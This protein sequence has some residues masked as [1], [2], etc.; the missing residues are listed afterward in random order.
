MPRELLLLR[1][2]K[3]DWSL[4]AEDFSR[5]LKD[6]GGRDAERMG[7]WL[8]R[9]GWI[10]DHWLCSP[11][12]RAKNTAERCAAAMEQDAR[13]IHYDE[14]IYEAG[15]SPLLEVLAGSPADAGCVILV[16][17]NPGLEDLL[18]H[19][20]GDRVPDSSDHKL[21]PTATLA[22]LT[23]P[24]DWSRLKAGCAH[25]LSIT[26]PGELPR[27]FPFPSPDGEELRKRPAY[28]YRQCAALPYRLRKGKAEFLLVTSRSGQH[29]VL[30]K[31]IQDPGL[32]PWEAAAKEALEEAGV[33]GRIEKPELGR[34]HYRKWGS[35]CEVK[36]FP[37]KVTRQL[38]ENEWP[39]HQGRKRKWMTPKKALELLEQ[40]RLQSLLGKFRKTLESTS[41]G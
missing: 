25:L 28:Y 15:L 32:S 33:E 11:A 36:V 38:D 21:L 31:G 6:R 41:Q 5:P 2:G 10:P 12:E 23:M 3:S 34:Y 26:R 37:M 14:R 20:T 18:I 8:Q 40:P 30:P 29:W 17:H 22:R 1:H 27:L 16:G 9:Q 24:E 7:T 19:L 39:E 35:E 13:R 4:N